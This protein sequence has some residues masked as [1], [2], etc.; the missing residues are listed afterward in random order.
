MK[1]MFTTLFLTSTLIN[2]Y[3]FY[4]YFQ[5]FSSV[6]LESIIGRTT[7]KESRFWIILLSEHVILGL[8][9]IVNMFGSSR[10]SFVRRRRQTDNEKEYLERYKR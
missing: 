2:F 3:H 1:S 8:F 10:L 6:T 7:L 9:V 4:E 5:N